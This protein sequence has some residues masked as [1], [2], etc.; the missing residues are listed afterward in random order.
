MSSFVEALKHVEKVLVLI[1]EFLITLLFAE[2]LKHF[3][4]CF[5][6]LSISLASLHDSKQ[7]FF[8]EKTSPSNF[9]S[10]SSSP[11]NGSIS[12]TVS[13]PTAFSATTMFGEQNHQKNVESV[14]FEKL[15]KQ[16]VAAT[17]Q[18]K[19][20][21]FEI[22][23]CN[24]VFLSKLNRL[25][26]HFRSFKVFVKWFWVFRLFSSKVYGAFK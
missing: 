17:G 5:R 24:N 15:L 3:S 21:D 20:F 4:F 14:N 2:V 12:P 18:V 13:F 11:F 26:L 7:D 16:N 10:V 6:L 25:I 8:E 1:T 19:S 9:S 22:E 23:L